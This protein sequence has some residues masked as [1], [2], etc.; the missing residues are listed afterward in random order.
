MEEI[1]VLKFDMFTTLMLAVLA[2]YFGDF[3]RK[4]FP[5]LKKY[6]LPASVVGGTVFALISLL[7]F[8]MGIVQLDFDY[9]AIN[10]LFYCIFFAAS[11]A[12]ASMALLKKG[13]KLVAIFAVLAAILAAC[14]NGM[15]LVVGK[16]MNIDPLISMMTGSI[17][18]TGGHGNAA[19]FA[20]IAVD[21]GAP[22]AIEVAIAAATFGLI[23][24]C[25][26]GGPFGNFLVKRFKLE[27]S[28]SNEQAM[29]EID[30]EGESGNLLVDKPNIIQ[31]VFLMCIAI[32]IG[33]IIEL[34]L[35]SIQENTGWKVALPIHVCCM[36][37]GIVIRLIYD[38]KEG[39]H[40]V[41]Y[42]SIDIVGE[43]SLAL[44]VSMSII[45]MKLWQLSGLGLALVVLLIAQLVLIVTF[46]YFLTFRLL[47]KNYDAAVMAVGHMGFGLGAVPVSM[48]TMQAVC[49]KYRYS[50][51]AFFVVP[52]IGG[53]ISNL[54]NAVII[55]K[56]L[57]L[58]KDLHTIWIS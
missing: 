45:T 47:G 44:F 5:I 15:A 19:S 32:G 6:C 30:A 53:F 26:L 52:V 4:I 39:N 12:A 34:G 56:F 24:G 50:K 31:A 40:D 48:T 43:F 16:F 42:E 58:A 35:K 37:A 54:T 20:P 23:S 9:K 14:Q 33:K 2:I 11:G 38:R 21:A 1:N 7:L 27:G 22:A 36:F 8:K 13:G 3:M 49:K 29:G 17:P 57:D 18:M 28:T 25:M 55:T 51:L 46:C 10:Q 41:L